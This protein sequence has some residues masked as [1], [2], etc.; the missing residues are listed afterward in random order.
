MPARGRQGLKI[1]MFVGTMFVGTWQLQSRDRSQ[2][3]LERRIEDAAAKKSSGD[4]LE[5][6]DISPKKIQFEYVGT[7]TMSSDHNIKDINS[8]Y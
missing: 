3:V 7:S 4:S 8:K 5:I 1:H 2:I 6:F